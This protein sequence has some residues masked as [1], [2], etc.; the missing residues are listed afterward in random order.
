MDFENYWQENKK[1][2]ISIGCGLLVF[3]IANLL[4]NSTVGGKLKDAKRD[5]A[6][7]QRELRQER[8]TS[9]AKGLAAEDNER[10]F[11]AY[12]ALAASVV[13]RT[14]PG[15]VP[16]PALGSVAGQ[17]FTRVEQ[18]RDRLSRRASRSGLRPPDDAWGIEM[19]DTNIEPV[20]VRHMEALDLI[21]RVANMAIDAGVSRITRIQVDLDSGF[22]SKKGLDRLERTKL[23]FEFDTSAAS[24]SSLITMTQTP[25]EGDE[26]SQALAI[27][28]LEVKGERNRAG[29]VKA[30]VTF[31]IVRVTERLGE[32][33]R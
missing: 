32:D 24:M 10:L 13:F 8:Y 12:G 3:M 20:I 7:K 6:D 2:V 22:G 4:V 15:F 28:E 21:D 17:Y 9:E 16:D 1:A 19:P 31:T 29:H 30:D 11:A 14:R 25:V 23:R 26:Q 5:R 27:D 18:V 33:A